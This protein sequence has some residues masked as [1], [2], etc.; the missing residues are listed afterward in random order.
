MK[1]GGWTLGEKGWDLHPSERARV[2]RERAEAF[3]RIDAAHARTCT[4]C[5]LCGQLARELDKFGLCSKNR[6]EHA[7][8]RLD[9]ATDEKTKART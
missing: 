8:W 2:D 1:D 5:A 4:P 7:E 6:G 9:V 3:A